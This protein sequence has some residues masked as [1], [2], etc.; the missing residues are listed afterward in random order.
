MTIHL[1]GLTIEPNVHGLYPLSGIFK[2]SGG[3]K[4]NRPAY[5]LKRADTTAYIDFLKAE[6]GVLQVIQIIQGGTPELQGTFVCR[7]LVYDYATWV[8]PALR[9]AVVQA[10]DTL[11]TQQQDLTRSLSL[12]LSTQESS[13][14]K[15]EPRGEQTLAVLLGCTVYESQF[16]YSWLL[17]NGY[18][19]RKTFKDGQSHYR[20][21]DPKAPWFDGFARKTMLFNEKILD[22]L[23]LDA[24][25]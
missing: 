5:W 12:A 8:S 6:V 2:A 16:Y 15:R 19:T 24:A 18:V 17:E 1:F 23:P 14:L 9:Y 21:V 10:F 7:E 3:L 4:N 25:E 20:P 22:I 11:L 13:F